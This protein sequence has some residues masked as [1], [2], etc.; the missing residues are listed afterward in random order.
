MPRRLTLVISSLAAGGAERVMSILA[1][2]WAQAGHAV[3]LITI[4]PVAGDHYTLDSRVQ[5]ID[6]S[7]SW[8]RGRGLG[9]LRSDATLCWLLRD[10]VRV[11]KPDV[12]V[13]FMDKI[14]LCVLIS[15]LAT[16]I[17][18]VIS[19]RTDPRRHRLGAGWRWLRRALYPLADVLVVQTQTVERWATDFLPARKVRVIPNPVVVPAA[20]SA[21]P[22]KGGNSVIAMGRLG[23]EK[24]FDL[25]LDAFARSQLPTAGWHLTILGDGPERA[26]L[27]TQAAAFGLT[28]STRFAGVVADPFLWL[29]RADIF[30]LSSRF[31]GFP[32]ALL[33]AMA[34]GLAVIAFDCESGPRAIV[35]P[36]HDGLLVPAEDVGALSKALET[37]AS[38]EALRRR[39]GDAACRVVDRYALRDV[40]AEWDAL[41]AGVIERRRRR[42]GPSGHGE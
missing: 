16:R 39:L 13:S 33:E 20:H 27:Q 17:P 38:D 5:R 12:V 23:R 15:L 36:D 28:P 26:A 22:V 41:L 25:L 31:E 40:G 11:T 8:K 37:L 14:N 2:R 30:V 10:A 19:E 9:A 42:A 24:G 18:V 29:R 34:C 32:N 3:T 4:A 35:R 21:P 7:L 1:S 6:L